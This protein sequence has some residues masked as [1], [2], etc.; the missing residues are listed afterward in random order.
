MSRLERFNSQGAEG[1]GLT[2]AKD[3]T[4]TRNNPSVEKRREPLPCH[5]RKEL[6]NFMK[7][8]MS[9]PIPNNEVSSKAPMSMR[10]RVAALPGNAEELRYLTPMPLRSNGRPEAGEILV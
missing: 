4:S 1:S 2:S 9:G 6:L 3:V 10:K 5:G 8:T 7:E